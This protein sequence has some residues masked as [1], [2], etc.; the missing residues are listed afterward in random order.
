MLP[1][2][3]HCKEIAQILNESFAGIEPLEPLPGIPTHPLDLF[4][5]VEEPENA[6]SQMVKI[7]APHLESA[8]SLNHGIPQAASVRK[9]HRQP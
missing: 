4:R 5:M 6:I 1:S 7:I 8:L 3:R 2:R 9:Q